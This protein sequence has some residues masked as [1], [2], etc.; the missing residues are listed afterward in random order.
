[1]PEARGAARLRAAL[2]Q[3]LYAAHAFL[4]WIATAAVPLGGLFVAEADAGICGVAA[5]STVQT[6]SS[7]RADV[8]VHPQWRRQGIGRALLGEVAGAARAW[9]ATR[10]R[11]WRPTDAEPALAFLDDLGAVASARLLTFEAAPDLVEFRRRLGRRADATAAGMRPLDAADLSWL[12]ELYAARLGDP[13]PVATARLQ[14]VLAD[15]L[16]G[17]LSLVFERRGGRAFLVF[18][19]DDDGVPRLDFWYA[20]PR[21]RGTAALAL[22]CAA[23]DRGRT[24]GV[25]RLRFQCRDDARSPLRLAREIG[26]TAVRT[27]TSHELAL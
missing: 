24:L 12:A 8:F 10:L 15:P 1:M 21:V 26:A 6:G 17:P 25:G 7:L 18:Q 9:G 4:P 23:I 14:S 20:D 5:L 3:D 11:S 13:L 16:A 19:P 2:P 22:L 27:Q